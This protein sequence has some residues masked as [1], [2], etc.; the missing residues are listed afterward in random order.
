M[1]IAVERAAAPKAGFVTFGVLR[2]DGPG[3]AA[4]LVRI[5][6]DEV[7][8]WVRHTE[9]FISS[10]VHVSADGTTVINRGEWTSEAAYRTSFGT[11]PAGGVLHAL[12]T[13]PGVLAATVFSGAPAEGAIEGPAAGERPGVVVVATRH[14]GGPES[15]HRLLDL[16]AR[17]GEWKRDFPGLISVTPYLSED[18]TEFV[19]Y[20]MWVSEVAYSS[21]M[22]DPRILEGQE[23][24]ARLEVAPPQ[25]VLCAVAAHVDAAARTEQKR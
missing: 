7:G 11:N 10:R 25:Y 17:S 13:R 4:S 15:A 20:P 12:G 6:T 5:L 23:E 14:L 1:S 9:G 21:W 24:L 2:V 16:L 18:G 19:N 8:S 22:A 3:T